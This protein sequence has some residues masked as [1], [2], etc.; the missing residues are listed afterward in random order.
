MRWSLGGGNVYFMDRRLV[1]ILML[2]MQLKFQKK[3]LAEILLRFRFLYKYCFIIQGQQLKKQLFCGRVQTFPDD[4]V[5]VLCF[6]HRALQW[7]VSMHST[8]KL[9]ASR[10]IQFLPGVPPLEIVSSSSEWI[11]FCGEGRTK[12]WKCSPTRCVLS[13]GQSPDS[14]DHSIHTC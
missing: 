1:F 12:D 6:L 10:N 9:K 13:F 4:L 5:F 14:S 2:T 3:V 8:R 11:S 7:R